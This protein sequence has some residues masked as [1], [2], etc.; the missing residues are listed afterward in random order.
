M[1]AKK[2]ASPTKPTPQGGERK[3]STGDWVPRFLAALR[4]EGTILHACQKANCD[5]S[6]VYDRR[7]K[8]PVFAAQLAAALDDS[9]DNLE[10]E[11]VRR[12]SEGYDEPV[13]Y[14]GQLMGVWRNQDGAEVA[15]DTPGA[16]FIPLTIR[17]Y[18]DSLLANLI[19]WR[20]Y[21][22]QMKVEH[23]GKDGGPIQINWDALSTRKDVPDPIEQRI[24][25]V[26]AEGDGGSATDG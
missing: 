23:S 24:A 6:N 2:K 10:R 5:R 8:D 17:K 22:E 12:G 7:D 19:K 4:K 26:E 11:A 13:I 14:Q 3:R 1:M 21:G 15:P 25:E 18:S 20:R 9:T 16:R